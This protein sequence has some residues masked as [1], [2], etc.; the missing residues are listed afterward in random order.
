MTRWGHIE[1]KIITKLNYNNMEFN[2]TKQKIKKK[3]RR[4][5]I[6]I[7]CKTLGFETRNPYYSAMKKDHWDDLTQAEE[8]V[9]LA[10]VDLIKDR[11]QKIKE[12]EEI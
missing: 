1:Y 3:L 8:K 10:A 2:T 6:G 9:I 12:A 4:G 7:I 11:A 5:D